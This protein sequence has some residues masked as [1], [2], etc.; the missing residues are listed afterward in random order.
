MDYR[1]TDNWSDPED[2]DQYYTEKLY[3]LP[4]GFLCYKPPDNAPDVNE[5]PALKNGYVTF[6]TFNTLAKINQK[7]IALWSQILKSVP[8]AKLVIKNKQLNDASVR[9]VYKQ[10]FTD[11]TIDIS[12]IILQKYSQSRQEHLKCYNTIDI[13]LDT[14]PYNGTATTCESLWMGVPVVTLAGTSHAGRVGVSL[15]S[16][17]GLKGMIAP[18]YDNYVSLAVFLAN[19]IDKVSQ[20]RKNLRLTLLRSPLCDGVSFTRTL[21]QAYKEIWNSNAK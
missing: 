4:Q 14:F 18:G 21:E 16:V 5:T 13:S 2:Q 17:I 10:Y 6:G 15:L 1:F 8:T 3:R 11:N 19:N 20:L 9:T 7:T 12:R